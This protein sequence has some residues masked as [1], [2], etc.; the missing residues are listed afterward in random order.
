[1]IPRHLRPLFWDTDV[2]DFDPHAYPVYTIA[3]VLEH[4]EENDIVWL[5][6]EFTVAQIQDVLRTNHHLSSRSA[7]FWALVFDLPA[8]EVAALS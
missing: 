4:G 7:N 2:E 5:R 3:R 6:R 8:H 1:M